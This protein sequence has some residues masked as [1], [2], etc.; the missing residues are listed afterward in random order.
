[1]MTSTNSAS[2]LA[3]GIAHAFSRRAIRSI[4]A[5]IAILC[6]LAFVS[7][8]EAAQ[9][10]PLE[11]T[12]SRQSLA[13]AWWT[14]PM[15]ANSAGT[16]PRGHI[17]V[18]P[19]FYDVHS[20]HSDSFGTRSYVLY[21]LFNK[22]TVGFIPITSF[23]EA[24][25]TPSSSRIGMGDLTL[26]AQ[27]GLT[28]S[29]DHSWIPATAINIQQSFPTASY[30]H[31]GN[32]PNN[33][34]GSGVYTTTLALN[35][36]KLFW[37]PNGRILRMR[38]DI[39]QSFSSSA[40]VQDVSVYGTATGFRG[41]AAP[42]RSSGVDAAWEYSLTRHWVLALDLTYG[43]SS[44]TRVSGYNILDSTGA[45]NPPSIVMNLGSSEAFGLAPAIEYNLNSNLGILLGT[46]IIP[47][48]H[49]TT[50]SITPAVAINFV[51]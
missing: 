7:N 17:L 11:C 35:S 13:D 26:V 47:F 49:N 39:S 43:H 10:A 34:F 42:G 27:Y 3:P 24:S 16:L 32:R 51:H 18:E 36:Q 40:N 31:L 50:P 2:L 38:F 1:M 48:G 45:E 15:L 30:D 33:G 12:E 23:N 25:G 28:K 14:G 29:H 8:I 46:R 37:L 5:T 22:L 4:F 19:Y 6:A 44:N 20:A 9:Q 41:T 21:G